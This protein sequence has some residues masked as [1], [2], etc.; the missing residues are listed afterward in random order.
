MSEE[1]RAAFERMDRFRAFWN[2]HY[3][4]FQTGIRTG[5]SQWLTKNLSATPKTFWNSVANWTV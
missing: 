5:S 3:A 4:E 1:T 2:A